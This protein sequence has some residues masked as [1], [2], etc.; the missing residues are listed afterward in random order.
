M[1]VAGVGVDGAARDMAALEGEGAESAVLRQCAHEAVLECEGFVAAVV[2]LAETEDGAI[3][4]LGDVIAQV[5]QGR[6]WVGR[7]QDPSLQR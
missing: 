2:R 5:V 4:V 3:G 6:L 7:R 1:Y